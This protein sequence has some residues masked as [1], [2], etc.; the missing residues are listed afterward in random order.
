VERGPSVTVR[1]LKPAGAPS[2]GRGEPAADLCLAL[3]EAFRCTEDAPTA[4][5]HAVRA[6][7]PA[8]HS[9]SSPGR[10]RSP[11]PGAAYRARELNERRLTTPS[12]TGEPD[13]REALR[14]WDE[15]FGWIKQQHGHDVVVMTQRS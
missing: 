10:S 6:R 11:D 3:I 13:I 8:T 14:Y 7:H 12:M 4:S 2:V 15:V 1:G 9:R 5:L